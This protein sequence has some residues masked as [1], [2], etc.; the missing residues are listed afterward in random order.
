MKCEDKKK[1]LYLGHDPARFSQNQKELFH[2]PIIQT[3]KLAI[4][5]L[6]GFLESSYLLV[7]SRQAVFCLVNLLTP[8]EKANFQKMKIISI[9]SATTLSLKEKGVDVA[10]QA[11]V[12]TAE[13]VVKLIEELPLKTED[14]FFYPHSALSRNIITDFFIQKNIKYHAVA[15]YTTIPNKELPPPD[16]KNFEEIIFTSPSTV[17]AFLQLYGSL[18]KNLKLTPLGPITANYLMKS[19]KFG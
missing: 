11:E 8:Q 13:G 17:D 14:C 16:L 19:T 6:E 3:K 10:H 12:A 4:D 2:F 9:G 7:T 5:S 18:P 1:I 15:L